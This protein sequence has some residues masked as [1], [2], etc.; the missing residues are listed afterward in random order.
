M[1]A[2]YQIFYYYDAVKLNVL[3]GEME[4]VSISARLEYILIIFFILG[5]CQN[6]FQLGAAA[7][8][9]HNDL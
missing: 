2:Q 6:L 4:N 3:S 8:A 9:C 1:M 7:I 5:P